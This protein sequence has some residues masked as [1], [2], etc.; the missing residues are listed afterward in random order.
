MI[1][2]LKVGVYAWP[3]CQD[4]MIAQTSKHAR[5][6][7]TA[8]SGVARSGDPQQAELRLDAPLRLLRLCQS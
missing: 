2:K 7:G 1:T 5:S 3:H 8:V 4:Y 6:Y